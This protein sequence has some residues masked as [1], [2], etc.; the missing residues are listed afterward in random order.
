MEHGLGE[1]DVAKVAL[2]VK[3]GSLAG[4]APV[5]A[6]GGT[7]SRIHQPTPK[8]R[9]E[10]REERKKEKKKKK[11]QKALEMSGEKNDDKGFF[12]LTGV[13]MVPCW[14]VWLVSISQT[15]ISR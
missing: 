12:Y 15:D 13:S 2:A 4:G 6:V 11:R 7:K 1:V 5:A 10:K 3:V 14:K 9:E 8:K